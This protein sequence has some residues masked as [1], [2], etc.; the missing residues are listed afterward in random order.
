M[1][2]SHHHQHHDPRLDDFDDVVTVLLRLKFRLYRSEMTPDLLDVYHAAGAD[3]VVTMFFDRPQTAG[4]N[5]V[6]AGSDRRRGRTR[7]LVLHYYCRPREGERSW[8]TTRQ[9]LQPR[10]LTLY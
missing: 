3:D 5:F 10:D 7:F 6:V 1:G 2:P 9:M 8:S 4:M